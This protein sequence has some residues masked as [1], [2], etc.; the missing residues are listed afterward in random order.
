MPIISV[1][2]P[3]YGVEKFILRCAKSLFEQ[4]VNNVEYIFVNDC[5]KDKSISL[6]EAFIE[7]YPQIKSDIRI[8]HH[9]VNKGLPQAR[10]TG[11]LNAKGKYILNCDSDD[12]LPNGVLPQIIQILQH[13][14]PDV[15]I[16]DYFQTD[17]QCYIPQCGLYS[18][19]VAQTIKDMLSNKVCCAV[20]NKIFKRQFYLEQ[21]L[22][23]NSNMAE[24]LAITMQLMLKVNSIS[25]FKQPAYCYYLNVNSMTKAMSKEIYV[26]NYRQIREN[27]DI[28]FNAIKN[29]GYS[30][31]L[32]TEIVA[33]KHK[34]RMLYLYPYRNDMD[35]RKLL[36]STDSDINYLLFLNKYISF[37][38]KL[39]FL[40]VLTNL[41]F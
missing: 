27:M 35:V 32:D 14:N 15:L 6:L 39:R 38:D 26:R 10:K 37:K 21:F 5:T 24:D 4:D 12:W 11:I 7:D 25:Y 13:E 18:S 19:D 8:I 30:G 36:I 1:V 40:L 41:R 22:F 34:K 2:V 28:V 29:S 17:E 31:E 20:W 9:D 16:S 33:L 23:P 3:V